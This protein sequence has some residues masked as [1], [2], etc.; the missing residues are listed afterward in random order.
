MRINIKRPDAKLEK[1]VL[2]ILSG[3]LALLLIVFCL[4]QFTSLFRADIETMLVT[5]DS[6]ELSVAG[7]G[8]L[9][10][11]EKAL[12]SAAGGMIATLV[13]SGA[14]VAKGDPMLEIYTSGRENSA[15]YAAL[16]DSI[17][18]LS[19]ALQE[20][21]TL[22]DLTD[23]LAE[24][25]LLNASLTDALG[26]GDAASAAVYREAIRLLSLR[27]DDLKSTVPILR[28]AIAELTRERDALVL[29][30]GMLG[31]TLTAETGGYFYPENDGYG[32]RLIAAFSD[33]MT[34]GDVR[35]L[36][37]EITALPSVSSDR[38]V[39][40]LVTDSKWYLA[41]P[42]ELPITE[43]VEGR[44]YTLIFPSENDERIPMTLERLTEGNGDEPS[45]FLFSSR[46]MPTGFSFSRQMRVKI[47]TETQSGFSIPTSAVHRLDGEVG[48][49]VLEGSVMC[50]CRVEILYD[51]G[52]RYLIKTTDP[53]PGGEYAENTYRYVRQYDLLV[54]S[55]GRLFHG[56]VLS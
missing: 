32:E 29:A 49:Y 2:R 11:S 18:L 40:T 6:I 53:T 31:E 44:E 13:E 17:R 26:R 43:F 23:L 33:E 21:D 4:Y 3:G 54:L 39:G 27:E 37:E 14:R 36:M 15:A 41:V 38:I 22:S 28:N 35:R 1:R 5:K 46:R 24:E 19:S 52:T 51:L 56:R 25:A 45:L 48:V 10:R 8:L 30:S 16:S 7:E 42:T 47:V 20:K 9:F 34:G 50:F 12:S 55:G